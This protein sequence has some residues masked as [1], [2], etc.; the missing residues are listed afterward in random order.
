[1]RGRTVAES[2]LWVVVVVVGDVVVAVVAVTT[3][4]EISDTANKY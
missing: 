2:A 4:A 1:M 3:G